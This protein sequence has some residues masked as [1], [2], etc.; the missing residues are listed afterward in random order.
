MKNPFKN[1]VLVIRQQGRT[2]KQPVRLLWE[3][4]P[5]GNK[6]PFIVRVFLDWVK[7]EEQKKGHTHYF[8]GDLIEVKHTPGQM[9]AVDYSK[10]VAHVSYNGTVWAGTHEAWQH[11]T[12]AFYYHDWPEGSD[13]AHQSPVL[14]KGRK[15]RPNWRAEISVHVGERKLNPKSFWLEGSELVLKQ[16]PGKYERVTVDVIDPKDFQAVGTITGRKEAA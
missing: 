9:W 16:H 11:P 7:V 8:W 12:K 5:L 14:P 10:V 15:S 4:G 6:L 2:P 13:M 3:S 1:L